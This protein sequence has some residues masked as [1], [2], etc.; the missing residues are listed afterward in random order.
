[1]ALAAP[2]GHA[3]TTLVSLAYVLWSILYRYEM[4][5]FLVSGSKELAINNLRAVRHELQEN[6]LL[7]ADFPE[8]CPDDGAMPK[9][10]KDSHIM[11]AS[12]PSVRAVGAGQRIRGSKHLQHRPSLVVADDLEDKEQTAS[13]EQRRKLW[14]WFNGT[15][16]KVGEPRTNVV[17]VGTILHYDALLAKLV[18]TRGQAPHAGWKTKVYRAVEAPSDH[19]ELWEQWEAIYATRQEHQG[20]TGPEAAALFLAAHQDAMLQGTRVL[21]PEREDYTALMHMRAREGRAAF[22]AEKQNEPL[23]PEECL[24]KESLFRYWDDDYRDAGELLAKLGRNATIVGACDPSMGKSGGRGDFT[25]LVTLA[26]DRRDGV[27]YVLDADLARRTPDEVFTR[28]VA[29]A[30]A[31]PYE[32]FALENN[33]FQD[34]LIPQVNERLRSEGKRLFIVGV[35][36]TSDKKG[37]IESLEPRVS[38]GSLRFCRRHQELLNQLRQFPLGAHDDGPDALEMAVAIANRPR[39]RI[40]VG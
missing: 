37:R 30:G 34:L 39:P 32:R 2:R 23:D 21:W 12:G 38:R 36:H 19:P 29:L 5:V 3:K 16:L 11:L 27:M 6:A 7:R 35:A 10:W 40:T 13:S 28:I 8:A 4:F 20:A 22:D 15:L 24:F 31:Y 9:P 26:I 14:E 25:A 18:G 1:L 33:G 17:V